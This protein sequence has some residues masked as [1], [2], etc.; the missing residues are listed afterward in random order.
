[1]N[2]LDWK[3]SHKKLNDSSVVPLSEVD[4]KNWR[5]LIH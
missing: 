2:Q 4:K 5:S 3:A 1:M